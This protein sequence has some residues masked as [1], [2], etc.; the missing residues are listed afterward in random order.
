MPITTD[1][2]NDKPDKSDIF[3]KYLQY[4]TLGFEFVSAVILFLVIGYFADKYFDTKPIGILIGA[5]VG[6]G[7]GLYSFIRNA[8][9]IDKKLSDKSKNNE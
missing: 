1:A 6:V 2:M 8:M 9:K 5:I 7:M 4:S 3:Q